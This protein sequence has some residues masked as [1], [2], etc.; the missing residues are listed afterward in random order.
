ML[1]GYNPLPAVRE[2]L[3]TTFSGTLPGSYKDNG[4]KTEQLRTCRYSQNSWPPVSPVPPIHHAS[5]NRSLLVSVPLCTKWQGQMPERIIVGRS[6]RELLLGWLQK[7]RMA[8]TANSQF[9]FQNQQTLHLVTAK[10]QN[11]A[12]LC[13]TKWISKEELLLPDAYFRAANQL[14]LT[15]CGS[16]TRRCN[17]ANTTA[18]NW[19]R[20]WAN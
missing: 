4:L 9:L 5:F 20:F 12:L 1:K 6:G 2:Y 17:T 15:Q 18:C 14:Q 3:V 8:A 7:M 13:W 10:G 11:W 16:R 19:K